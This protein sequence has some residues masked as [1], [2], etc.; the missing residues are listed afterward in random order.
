[1]CSE[2]HNLGYQEKDRG[3]FRQ[4]EMSFILGSYLK[5]VFAFLRQVSN[6]ILVLGVSKVRAPAFFLPFFFLRAK[7][8]G[9]NDLLPGSLPVNSVSPKPP[10]VSHKVTCW[11]QKLQYQLLSS[12]CPS[13]SNSRFTDQPSSRTLNFCLCIKYKASLLTYSTSSSGL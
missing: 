8:S 4:V 2:S 5:G 6:L 1:M 12:S 3:F 9:T 10:P 11:S 7:A 13:Q